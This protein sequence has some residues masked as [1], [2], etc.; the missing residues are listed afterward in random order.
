MRLSFALVAC[1]A[2]IGCIAAWAQEPRLAAE[3]RGLLPKPA[4]TTP[5]GRT[6]ANLFYTDPSGGL[7]R[8]IFETDEDPDFRLVI[9]DFSFAPAHQP[10]TVAL[11]SSAFV[12]LLSGTGE[13]SVAKKR[14]ELAPG[15]RMAVPAGT[16]IEV[17]NNGEYPVVVRALI[18]EAK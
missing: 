11:P 2:T 17:V 9:R 15:A 12:H 18:V 10:H 6:S 14:L 3:G 1:F 4:E 13:I 16:Q 7:S 5:E 8:T